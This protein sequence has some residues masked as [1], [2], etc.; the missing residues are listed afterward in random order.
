MT[1]ALQATQ[2]HAAALGRLWTRTTNHAAERPIHC[3]ACGV[4]HERDALL[5]IVSPRRDLLA[6]LCD[7]CAELTS[8][9][10]QAVEG[11]ID[12]RGRSGAFC[13]HRLEDAEGAGLVVLDADCAC[14]AGGKA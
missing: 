13:L 6:A 7:R 9:D 2:D 4:L 8:R 3:A 12:A 10:L 11:L 1:T 14:G 5:H